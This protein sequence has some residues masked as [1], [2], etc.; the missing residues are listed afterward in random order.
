MA[1]NK[2][3]FFLIRW[4]DSL[5]VWLDDLVFPASDRAGLVAGPFGYS[6]IAGLA[7]GLS[8]GIR[9][10]FKGNADVFNT[11]ASIIALIFIVGVIV[12]F[13]MKDLTA[14]ET[15]G[16]KIGRSAYVVVLCGVGFIAGFYLSVLAM[17]AVIAFGVL[18]VLYQAVFGSSTD[19]KKKIRLDN[20]EEL[21]VERGMCGE[22]YYTGSSGKEYERVSQDSFKEK[23]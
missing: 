20:G 15:T 21:T 1:N 23:S 11:T 13:L 2:K 18:W 22:E 3:P 12:L 14:F 9:S 7:L 16:E 5:C 10:F 19:K 6:L 4:I 8:M 17:Y